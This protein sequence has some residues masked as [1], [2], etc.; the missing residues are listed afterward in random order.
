M[1]DVEDPYLYAAHPLYEWQ[2]TEFGQWVMEHSVEQ[3]TFY[4]HNDLAN[5]GFTVVV[6][7][8]LSDENLTYF[9]LKYGGK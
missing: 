4:C 9:Q 8:V 1:G 7:A 2:Q 3:P 5:M 6:Y